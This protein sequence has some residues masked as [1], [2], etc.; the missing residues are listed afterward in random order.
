MQFSKNLK[1]LQSCDFF[2]QMYK[3]IQ[4]PL[5]KQGM[6]SIY[7]ITLKLEPNRLSSCP[8]IKLRPERRTEIVLIVYYWF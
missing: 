2:N 1:R 4:T 5:K 7:I 3:S 6:T 8:D